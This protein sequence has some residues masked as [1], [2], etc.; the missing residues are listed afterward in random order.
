MDLKFNRMEGKETI[1]PLRER[2]CNRYCSLPSSEGVLF[3]RP[4][5]GAALGPF[6]STNREQST[7]LKSHSTKSGL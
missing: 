4:C 5:L 3:F 1:S 2:P 7:G 6:P